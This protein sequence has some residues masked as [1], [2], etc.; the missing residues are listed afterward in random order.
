MATEDYKRLYEH[1]KALYEDG[2]YLEAIQ[3]LDE[4]AKDRPD[5][6]HVMF[7]RGLCLVNLGQLKDAKVLC[8]RL[9][10]LHGS[11]ASQFVSKIELKMREKETE[12]RKINP[13]YRVSSVATAGESAPKSG[14]NPIL[15]LFV[16]AIIVV[17][18]VAGIFFATRSPSPTQ[19]RE[20]VVSQGAT[21]HRASGDKYLE[22]S[23]FYPSGTEIGFQAIV[24]LAPQSGSSGAVEG[25][26][27]DA[28][29]GVVAANWDTVK[30][31]SEEALA[32]SGIHGESADGHDLSEMVRTVV[33]PKA[34]AAQTA[35]VRTETFTPGPKTS[36]QDVV[37]SC[38]SPEREEV[39]SLVS[40]G[41]NVT[42]KVNWWGRVGL[43]V[44]DGGTIS[45][46]L[47]RHSPKGK[48][49]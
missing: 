32:L 17:G 41:V 12:L 42:G 13:E 16:G 26:I 4:L 6:K 14:G 29:G 47:V 9:M 48:T 24:V 11:G 40:D 46:L 49:S 8:D 25:Q 30:K 3:I 10:H 39:W 2:K 20:A 35:E 19:G 21:L 22:V 38:G 7:T 23:T 15:W 31:H 1:A 37:A 33:F 28:V 34:G 43:A 45:H 18:V 36:L 27:T 44:D 5:S